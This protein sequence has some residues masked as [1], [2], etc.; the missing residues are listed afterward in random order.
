[1]KNMTIAHNSSIQNPPADIKATYKTVWEYRNR[2]CSILLPIRSAY[3][4]QSQSL[5]VSASTDDGSVDKYAFL[6]MKEGLEDGDV[7]PQD[8]PAAQ[9]IR[10]RV[11]RRMR[12]SNTLLLQHLR[13]LPRDVQWLEETLMVS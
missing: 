10:T 6:S 11:C 9:A 1:M 2:K 8:E 7:L 3:I 13:L 4:C 12:R 5:N